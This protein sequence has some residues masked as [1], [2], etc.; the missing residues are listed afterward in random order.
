MCM[1]MKI[2][3]D[4]V[5]LLFL[6][7]SLSSIVKGQNKLDK[8]IVENTE[9]EQKILSFEQEIQKCNVSIQ[10]KLSQISNDSLLLSQLLEDRSL[11]SKNNSKENLANLRKD[12]DSLKAVN[13]NILTEISK[14]DTLIAEQKKKLDSNQN[15]MANMGAFSAIQ[16]QKLYKENLQYLKRRFSQINIDRLQEMLNSANDFSGMKSHAEYVKR[17]EYALYIKKVFEDGVTT[18][19]S[20]FDESAVKSIRKQIIESSLIKKDDLKLGKF[21]LSDEQ[22]SELDS[23]DIKLSRYK[24]G[25]KFLKNTINKINTD[26]EIVSLRTNRN[27]NNRTQLLNHIKTYIM[28]DSESEQGKSYVRYIKMVP[29]LGKLLKQYWNEVKKDAFMTPTKTESIIFNTILED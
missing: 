10:Q 27:R 12:V 5:I 28:P 7:C 15:T 16:K 6:F 14:I 21:K 13:D 26:V 1:K 24:G 3:I 9:I 22:F 19:N 29:Y 23:L 2:T 11:L 25:M 20:P 17:L 18:I 4:K 8:V